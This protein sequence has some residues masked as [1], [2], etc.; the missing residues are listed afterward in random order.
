MTNFVKKALLAVA[1]F[2][3]NVSTGCHKQNQTVI[4]IPF[5][6]FDVKKQFDLLITMYSSKHTLWLTAKFSSVLYCIHK[7]GNMQ[8]FFI[9]T[10]HTQ[11]YITWLILS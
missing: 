9:D 10:L 3:D 5:C 4:V 2:I 11:I 7:T 8:L 6:L 1:S